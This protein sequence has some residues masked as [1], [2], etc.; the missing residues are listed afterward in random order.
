MFDQLLL[1]AV[2]TFASLIGGAVM[3]WALNEVLERMEPRLSRP[4]YPVKFLVVILMVVMLWSEWWVWA[5]FALVLVILE[6]LV[7]AYLFLG[8]GI[9]AGVMGLILWIGNAVRR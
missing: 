4:R 2:V 3:W 5:A 8:F 9:G 1:G 7:P 6:I